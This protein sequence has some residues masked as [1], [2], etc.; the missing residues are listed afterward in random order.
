MSSSNLELVEHYFEHVNAHDWEAVAAVT[1]P[2]LST[3]IRD[4]LWISHPDLQIDVEW[5][6]AHGDK[7][8]VWCFGR[9]TH[10]VAWTLPPSAGGLAGATIAPTGRPWRA[11]CST[12]YRIA[13]GRISEVWA[14]WDWLGVLDQLGVIKVGE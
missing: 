13:D 14:V 6:G 7:V 12:T 2:A 4:Y 10:S 11:A 9:G 3:A 1:V 5:M 8:S